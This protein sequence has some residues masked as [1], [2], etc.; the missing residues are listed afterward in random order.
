[1]RNPLLENLISILEILSYLYNNQLHDEIQFDFW[2]SIRRKFENENTEVMLKHFHHTE[3][4]ISNVGN[5][6]FQNVHRLRARRD[7]KPR[8][9]KARFVS[10][11]DHEMVRKAA[12]TLGDKP[13]YTINQQYPE[14][15][16]ERRRKLYP[17]K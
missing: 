6:E 4:Y 14:Q 16:V 8:T 11:K 7:G 3:L 2:W 13:Q 9:I 17:K 12:P 15:I 1:M 5:I 10:Y